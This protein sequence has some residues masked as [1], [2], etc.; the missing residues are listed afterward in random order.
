MS[1]PVNLVS[2]APGL[3]RR[4]EAPPEERDLHEAIRE[5]EG[6]FVGALLRQA[7]PSGDSGPMGGG[8]G[9][10]LYQELFFEE[11]G[12]LVAKRSALGLAD[13]LAPLGHLLR[14]LR[15]RHRPQKEGL[16]QVRKLRRAEAGGKRVRPASGVPK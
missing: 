13:Q 15:R 7:A 11:I 4:T 2:L 12:K 3:A 16:R 14:D 9:G 10:K 8:Q 6:Y 5:F 1:A